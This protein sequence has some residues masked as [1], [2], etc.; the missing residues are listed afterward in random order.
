M[1]LNVR[2]FKGWDADD[3][4]K[5]L[6][7]IHLSSLIPSFERIGIV[8]EDLPSVDDLFIREKLRMTKPAEVM[9]L[10]GAISNLVDSASAAQANIARRKSAAPRIEI[11]SKERRESFTKGQSASVGGAVRAPL[12]RNYTMPSEMPSSRQPQLKQNAAATDLLDDHCRYSG[13]I[14]KQG[15]GY[16]TCKLKCIMHYKVKRGYFDGGVIPIVKLVHVSLHTGEL[17]NDFSFPC[18]V[19]RPTMCLAVFSFVPL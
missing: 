4:S 19:S 15:G 7:H 6:S 18:E 10:K 8:G 12:P 5:W 9:A 17:A 16:K 14:R 2:N 1:A 13:W 11:D 3:V